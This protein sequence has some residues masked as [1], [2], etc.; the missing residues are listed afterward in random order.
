MKKKLQKNIYAMSTFLEMVISILLAVVITILIGKLVYD[1]IFVNGMFGSEDSLSYIIST[2]MN[3]AVGL[4][5]I[6]MLVKHT[7]GTV[8]EVLIFAIARQIVI[9]HASIWD[10]LFGVVCIVILFATRK[11]LF[12]PKDDNTEIDHIT[13]EESESDK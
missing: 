2:S 10:T 11:F 6:K 3:L 12:L 8:V 7:P 5:L 9:A 4:E 13:E 1:V